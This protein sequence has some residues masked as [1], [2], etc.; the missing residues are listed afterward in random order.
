MHAS[1]VVSDFVVSRANNSASSGQYLGQNWRGLISKSNTP[2][3]RLQLDLSTTRRRKRPSQIHTQ[4]ALQRQSGFL[5]G[6]I[7]NAIISVCIQTCIS[8][9]G[10]REIFDRAAV[11]SSNLYLNRILI[12][13][14][15]DTIIAVSML[16]S[17][18]I[19]V[20][21]IFFNLQLISKICIIKGFYS[22]MKDN[23]H[24]EISGVSLIYTHVAV[25]KNLHC[26]VVNIYARLRRILRLP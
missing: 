26:T 5:I 2:A 17:F 3:A 22:M 19:F 23:L 10:C 13:D 4:I 14:V 20:E 9:F 16:K 1:A 7:I 8:I 6:H 24:R 15:A 21:K 18:N 25:E 11:L 12:C